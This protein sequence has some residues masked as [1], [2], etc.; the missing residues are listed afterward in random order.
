MQMQMMMSTNQQIDTL[1]QSD[2]LQPTE[3]PAHSYQ[4]PD[5]QQKLE[6]Q[7]MIKAEATETENSDKD[8][9][10]E[11]GEGDEADDDSEKRRER[12]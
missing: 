8:L 11:L 5:A 4:M 2:G 6:Y 7:N 12:R 10:R 1:N 9:E 3:L